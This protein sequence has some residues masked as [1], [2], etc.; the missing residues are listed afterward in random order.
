MFDHGVMLCWQLTSSALLPSQHMHIVEFYWNM[1]ANA[2]DV[3]SRYGVVHAACST[4]APPTH[5]VW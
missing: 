5:D 2:C 4:L 3:I 1:V